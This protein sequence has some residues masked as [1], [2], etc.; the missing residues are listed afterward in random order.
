MVPL[1]CCTM[2]LATSRVMKKLPSKLMRKVSRHW[3]SLISSNGQARQMPA[4]WISTSMRPCCATV[5]S[6]KALHWLESPT[7]NAMLCTDGAWLRSD[8][9]S[10][11]NAASFRSANTKRAPSRANNS[12]QALPMPDAAPVMRMDLL[13]MVMLVLQI[14]TQMRLT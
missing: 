7:S 11:C 10:V 4:A 5:R 8:A 6:T 14:D 3:S 9:L 12:A 13:R 2:A 1:F